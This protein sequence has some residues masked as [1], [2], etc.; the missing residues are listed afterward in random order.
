[1]PCVMDP[2]T[3]VGAMLTVGQRYSIDV[4]DM[5]ALP[6]KLM[7]LSV[8]YVSKTSLWAA[9]FGEDYVHWE[10]VD[11][12]QGRNILG[13][14]AEWLALLSHCRW[15]DVYKHESTLAVAHP[16]LHVLRAHMRACSLD[17]GGEDAWTLVCRVFLLMLIQGLPSLLHTLEVLT[18]GVFK[19]DTHAG[20]I[21]L[22]AKQAEHLFT[23]AQY[24]AALNFVLDHCAVDARVL[25]QTLALCQAAQ[26]ERRLNLK[27]SRMTVIQGRP[28]LR[29]RVSSVLKTEERKAQVDTMLDT[30]E[31][32]TGFC[33][34]HQFPPTLSDRIKTRLYFL[35]SQT[36]W[37]WAQHLHLVLPS[38]G[39]L[40]AKVA[41]HPITQPVS[42]GLGGF[43]QG[44]AASGRLALGA[45]ERLVVL[46]PHGLRPLH[47]AVKG[48]GRQASAFSKRGGA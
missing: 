31:S 28:R 6:L 3:L 11:G 20:C 12:V 48:G 30:W 17:T 5:H 32:Y 2:H 21:Q 35:A 10:L 24:E 4:R 34:K 42:R 27:M 15:A 46:H 29:E 16:P 1:M 9:R 36:R 23:P 13:G 22:L 26:E 33:Y 43:I 45:R 8:K 14:S 41:A 47:Q 19:R 44:P 37:D 18:C 7:V 25:E 39:P 40:L 38:A